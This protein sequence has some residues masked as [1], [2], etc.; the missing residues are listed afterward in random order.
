MF[1]HGGLIPTN[2]RPDLARRLAAICAERLPAAGDYPLIRRD[3]REIDYLPPEV[4]SIL[5]HRRTESRRGHLWTFGDVGM[6]REDIRGEIQAAIDGK[7]ERFPKYLEQ[8]ARCWLL[9]A[10][11]PS[12]PSGFMDPDEESLA[13]EYVSPFDRSYFLSGFSGSARRLNTH[14]PG[15]NEVST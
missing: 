9:L 12:H 10:V 5:I 7:T 8:C 2:R 1:T 13:H 15:E 14:P 11:D 4:E 3:F 6:V